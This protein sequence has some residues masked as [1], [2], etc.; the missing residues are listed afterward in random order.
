MYPGDYIVFAKIDFNRQYEKD[1][2]VNLA[3]YS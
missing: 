1:Y 3:V 2:A